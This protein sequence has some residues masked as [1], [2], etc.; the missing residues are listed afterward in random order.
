MWLLDFNVI[1]GPYVQ[2]S[3]SWHILLS[4]YTT[5]NHFTKTIIIMRGHACSES[6]ELYEGAEGVN[7]MDVMMMAVVGEGAK[8]I[9]LFL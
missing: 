8:M 1:I 3:T 2:L 7:L 9:V 5:L 4:R 6:W